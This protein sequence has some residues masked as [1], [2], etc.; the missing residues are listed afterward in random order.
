MQLAQQAV[1]LMNI[2]IVCVCVVA[3]VNPSPFHVGSGSAGS[4]SY[5]YHYCVCV[6]RLWQLLEGRRRMHAATLTLCNSTCVFGFI[7]TVE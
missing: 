1:L 6:T 5:E 2:I 7:R 4:V 3:S